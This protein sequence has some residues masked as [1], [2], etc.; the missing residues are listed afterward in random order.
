MLLTA[1][2]IGYSILA[3]GLTL[4]T[5]VASVVVLSFACYVAV[6][7][8]AL[9]TDRALGKKLRDFDLADW[10][11]HRDDPYRTPSSPS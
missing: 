4:S 9:R 11:S 8:P 1:Y 7:D 6:A 3:L 10:A 5:T 2:L